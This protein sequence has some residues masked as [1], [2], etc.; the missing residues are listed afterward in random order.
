MEAANAMSQAVI[1]YNVIPFLM[2]VGFRDFQHLAWSLSAL[3]ASLVAEGLK[4]L[5]VWGGCV[6]WCRRPAGAAHCDLHNRGGSA[7]G[8]PGWPSG[9][10]STAAAFWMGA[11]L[12]AP[13][14]WRHWVAA[15]GFVGVGAMA[16]ARMKKRCHTLFQTI[17]GSLL[18]AGLAWVFIKIGTVSPGR[19]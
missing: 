19:H 4:H 10:C 18:G 16:A 6:D 11:W 3:L 5:T 15:A 9:H 8:E 12:L 13:S 14:G 1:A 17:S 2:L 7:A